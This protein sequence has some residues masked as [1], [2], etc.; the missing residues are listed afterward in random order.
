[1]SWSSTTARPTTPRPWRRAGGAVVL[2]L[3]FNLGIGGALRT[4]FRYA[5][6][7]GLRPGVQ[8]DADGQHDPTP[9]A[10]LFAALDDADLVIGSRFGGRPAPTRSAGPVAG[11]AAAAVHAAASCRAAPSP[12]PARGSGRSA[13]R[14]SSTSPGATRRST[15]SRSRRSSRPTTR[16]SASPRCP[17]R[18]TSGRAAAPSALQLQADLPLRAGDG[19]HLDPGEPSAARRRRRHLPCQRGGVRAGRPRADAP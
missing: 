5:V 2:R 16:G 17:S 15:W 12:T 1:M 3:P 11:D 9:I 7:P 8:F 18:C 10:A 6:R 4:G 13:G 19:H 14:C